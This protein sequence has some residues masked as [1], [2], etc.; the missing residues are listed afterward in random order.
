MEK[1]GLNDLRKMFLEFFESKGH[2]KLDSFS[3]IPHNDKSLL[4]INSGMAPLKPYFT[5]QETPPS[6]RV[7]TCQKCIR[8]PDIENV[9]K[10]ARHGTFFEMLGNFSFGDYF[11]HEA[12]AWA[13]EFMTKVVSIPEELLYVTVYQDDDEAFDIWK[14]EIGIPEKKIV[15]MGKEDNF[16]EIGLGPCGPCSEIYVDRGEAFGCGSESCY[17][18]CDCDR[19]VE[20]WNLVFTQFDKDEEG[21]YNK[22]KHPNIDTGMGLERLA[23]FSQG[24]NNLF[25]VDTVRYILDHV[26][27]LANVTY[28]KD[29]KTDVSIRVITDHIRSVVFMLS[30]GVIPSNEGRGYVL[31]RLLR[32]AVRHGK[33]LGIEGY[34]MEEVAKRVI[35][36]SKEAYPGLSE[37]YAGIIKIIHVEEVKF[38]ETIAQGMEL[39]KSIVR[40]LKEH[41]A[42]S[43][44]GADAFKLYDT[45]GFPLELTVELAEEEKMDVD[46]DGFNAAMKQQ[47]KQSTEAHEKQGIESWKDE[48][49]QIVAKLPATVFT[50]YDTLTD[51]S[52]VICLVKNGESV[53]TAGPGEDC[54]MIC[55]K[56][57]FYAQSGGQ[58]GDIGVVETAVMRA[59]VNDVLKSGDKFAHYITVESGFVSVNDPVTLLV[60]AAYRMDVQRNHTSTHLLHKAL[61]T[62]LGS[63]VNQA[64]SE[65]SADRLRFDFSHFEKMTDE[66][67]GQAEAIVNGEI[68]KCTDVAWFELPIAEAKKLGATA[69]FGEKYGTNVRVV[70]V[71]EFSMELC[72]GCHLTN[73]G[74]A[75]LF[76]IVSESGVAAGVRRIEAV[77]GRKAY[78]YVKHIE[79][80]LETAATAAKTTPELLTQRIGD[81]MENA[82][83]LQKEINEAKQKMNAGSADELLAGK[84]DVNGTAC[85]L[86]SADGLNANELRDLSDKLR[87]RLQSGVVLLVSVSEGKGTVLACATK[88]VVAKGFNSGTFVKEVAVSV[89]SSGGGRPDMAQAGLKDITKAGE[90][91][92]NAKTIIRSFL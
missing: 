43:I 42:L 33:L 70:K 49:T 27:R 18:G 8:T 24:V 87:D 50:G 46:L 7:T 73:I 79:S 26:C 6:K 21:N 14:N 78:D 59:R 82:S 32:R 75:G 3:L 29:A 10:T 88:D 56:T 34:F 35:E 5:G 16:W 52:N 39:M 76:K 15:R 66:Q 38:N 31:R 92:Q 55:E 20:V 68:L 80:A 44:P 77:T 83:K 74:Y 58:V 91:L 19:Y 22:L 45:Y 67:I 60:D 69:L 17:V 13:W 4:L 57:P 47:K 53:D 2:L 71:G 1:Y 81:I 12:I 85:I 25:E 48:L 30:D 51:A 11:K 41:G 65:V 9:G 28:E 54:V 63:H 62:V 64:G 23:A 86:A 36:T 72:G 37:N 84:I 61:K 40:D 89:G 90:A